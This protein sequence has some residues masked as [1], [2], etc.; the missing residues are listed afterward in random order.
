[1]ISQHLLDYFSVYLTIPTFYILRSPG[2]MLVQDH[3]VDLD[4]QF[5]QTCQEISNDL[6]WG[7][8][9]LQLRDVPQFL[10]E[11]LA[12]PHYCPTQGRQLRADNA[13]HHQITRRLG[14]DT[15]I[16]R[17]VKYSLCERN[18]DQCTSLQHNTNGSTLPPSRRTPMKSE[19]FSHCLWVSHCAKFKTQKGVCADAK[20]NGAHLICCP[21]VR[22]RVPILA[23]GSHRKPVIVERRRI[24]R[25]SQQIEGLGDECLFCRAAPAPFAVTWRMWCSTAANELQP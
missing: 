9:R 16:A 19:P 11:R 23:H 13:G 6:R 15:C 3:R 18:L 5:G 20:I 7:V 25:P 10:A 4:I 17:L 2:R 12:R 24:V 8:P 1:M 14:A 21:V 22:H